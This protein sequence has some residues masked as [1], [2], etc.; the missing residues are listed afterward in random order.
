[1]RRLSLQS[2]LSHFLLT[3]AVIVLVRPG[4][5]ASVLHGK[6]IDPDSY[7][8]L[9]RIRD[10]TGHWFADIVTRDQ[11]GRGV[12]IP[13]SHVFDAPIVALSAV[14]PLYWAGA[15]VGLFSVGLLGMAAAWA[16]KPLAPAGWLWITPVAIATT[17][18]VINYGQPGCV[19][20]HVLLAAL[21]AAAWGAGARAAFGDRRAGY[22]TGL[23]AGLGIWVSPE[24]MPFALMAVVAIAFSWTLAPSRP[25]AKAVAACDTALVAT[26]AIALVLDPP[27][28]GVAAPELDRLSI[29][30]LVQALIIGALSCLPL[31]LTP[32]RSMSA[33][34]LVLGTAGLGGA[35]LWLALFPAYVHGL[36]GLM[37]PEQAKDFFGKIQ[38]MQPMSTPTRVALFGLPGLLATLGPLAMAAA[39]AATLRRALWLFAA[40]CCLASL[41]LAFVHIRFA[42]YPAVAAAMAP[43]LLIAAVNHTSHSALLRP[44]LLALF[45]GAPPVSGSLLATPA[46]TALMK[47]CDLAAA[48]PVLAPYSGAVVLTNVND[49]PELLYRT[50]IKI[51]GSLYHSGIPGFMRLRA[52]WRARNLDQP[53][54]ELRATGAQ[55]VLACPGSSRP[56]L[57]DGP[58]TTLFD[59]LK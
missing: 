31:V 51:V 37:T 9:V 23:F 53:P 4:G 27:H 25:T 52:A 29:V 44:A 14:V 18:P 39:N 59:R 36:A 3:M 28:A 17:A 45:L 38:E 24:A 12:I 34:F 30:F 49:G 57:L 46:E 48:A 56:G 11:S 2:P 55:Y 26:L 43:P 58:P 54:P 21:A 6:L 13:W 41:T 15:L 19:T 33:R 5:D 35:A 10:T 50:S 16:V 40:T 20:H 7:M 8:R 22:L 47:Q 42:I 1:M 32:A